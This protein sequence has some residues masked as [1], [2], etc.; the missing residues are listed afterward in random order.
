MQEPSG[1]VLATQSAVEL[2]GGKALLGGSSQPDRH[3]PLG[4]LG[5]A[6]FHDCASHYGKVAAA[7][8]LSA[9]ITARLLGRVMREAATGRANGAIRPTRRFKPSACRILVVEVFALKN[10]LCH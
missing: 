1:I 7:F 9:A 6:P 10:V 2:V 5:M 8:L 4:E 3:S